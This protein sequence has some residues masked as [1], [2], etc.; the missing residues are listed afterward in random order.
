MRVARVQAWLGER[1]PIAPLIEALRHKRVPQH[2]Y[3]VWYYFG[4]ITLFLFVVQVVTGGLLLL[5]VL[6]DFWTLNSQISEANLDRS[7]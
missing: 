2:R 7:R 4:G 6:Y 3:S 1:V 5:G